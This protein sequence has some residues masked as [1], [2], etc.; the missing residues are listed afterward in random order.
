MVRT[1]FG[2]EPDTLDQSAALRLVGNHVG[3]MASCFT[4]A[5]E[6][7]WQA[8]VGEGTRMKIGAMQRGGLIHDIAAE[9]AKERIEDGEVVKKCSL[10]FFKV[11]FQSPQG[12]IVVRFLKLKSD[13]RVSLTG[14]R[15]P[16]RRYY[17]GS[18][19]NNIRPTATRLTVGYILDPL[20]T[21]IA[22]V[23]ITR[24]VGED[25][26]WQ[27]SILSHAD[28]WRFPVADSPSQEHEVQRFKSLGGTDA[29]EAGA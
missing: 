2:T 27:E 26:L 22:D 5:W 3:L 19:L 16:T 11:Y 24:Q 8:D 20:G 29:R 14:R 9:L 4:D 15:Q 6:V 1:L 21:E 28:S 17:H 23:R 18:H 25:V 7:H 13:G 10:G 12:S